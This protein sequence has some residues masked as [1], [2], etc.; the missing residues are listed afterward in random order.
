MVLC[1][2]CEE[3]EAVTKCS[4]CGRW[5]CEKHVAGSVCIVCKELM[6]GICG[7]RLSV[8]R[9]PICGKLICRKC[10]IELQPGIRVCKHCFSK[11]DQVI[12]RYPSL[13]YLTRFLAGKA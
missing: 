13:A 2:V 9:C 1:E 10:S 5:V 11:L 7:K 3:R 8:S 6:C 12:N 4:L